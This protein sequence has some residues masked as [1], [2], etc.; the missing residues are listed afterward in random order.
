MSKNCKKSHSKKD[1]KVATAT[2]RS[3]KKRR[4]KKHCLTNVNDQ[5]AWGT[6]M[7]LTL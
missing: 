7:P 4:L 6:L 5:Q 3:N 2:T 1:A